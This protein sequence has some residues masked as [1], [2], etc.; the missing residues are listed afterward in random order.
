VTQSGVTGICRKIVGGPFRAGVSVRGMKTP[1]QNRLVR[2]APLGLI[3]AA[4]IAATASAETSASRAT[5]VAV[6]VTA[7]QRAVENVAIKVFANP[8]VTAQIAESKKS[9]LA[10]TRTVMPR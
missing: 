3:V 6:L 9:F 7:A 2:V 4:A 1:T 8:A 5:N 10:T